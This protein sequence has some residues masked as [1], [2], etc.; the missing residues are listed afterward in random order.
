MALYCQDCSLSLFGQDFGD[1]AG[2][3]TPAESLE[4][5][6]SAVCCEGCGFIEVNHEGR[7]MLAVGDAIPPAP[8]TP[9][10]RAKI[11]RTG[12]VSL[13][14]HCTHQLVR[15]KGGF[16]FELVRDPLGHE[17]RVHKACV[18]LAIGDGITHVRPAPEKN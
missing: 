18:E 6:Y 14:W 5:I 16:I 1:F 11:W 2:E 7:R 17:H 15:E 13:C 8:A 12:G 9:D 10:S 3:T 4:K